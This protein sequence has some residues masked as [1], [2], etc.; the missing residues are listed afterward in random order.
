MKTR[1]IEMYVGSSTD[2]TWYTTFIE[3]PLY[4]PKDNIE[5]LAIALATAELKIL[6]VQFAFVGVYHI[7]EPEEEEK[8]VIR[9]SEGD[10]L[11][12]TDKQENDE[13]Q[14][15]VEVADLDDALDYIEKNVKLTDEQID[16]LKNGG[17]VTVNG[18]TIWIC[19]SLDK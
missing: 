11:V 7:P 1:R 14:H 2:H 17:D 3:I 8:W 18:K 9:I 4:T 13:Y 16:T 12:F 15:T 5:S 6:N 19:S 10:S